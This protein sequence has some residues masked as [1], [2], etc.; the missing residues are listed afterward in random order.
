MVFSKISVEE[1]GNLTATQISKPQTSTN[2]EQPQS[3]SE[4]LTEQKL[5]AFMSASSTPAPDSPK[6]HSSSSDDSHEDF[7]LEY[8][9]P[10][11][12]GRTEVVVDFRS[13]LY[14]LGTWFLITSPLCLFI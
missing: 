11:Q 12:S 5:E 1:D 7:S 14:S 2:E 13:D 6:K 8:M 3:G 9:S 4:I 10:E